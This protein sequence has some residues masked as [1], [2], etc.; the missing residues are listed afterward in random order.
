MRDG[1][2]AAVPPRRSRRAPYGGR[3]APPARPCYP[4]SI[5]QR[6]GVGGPGG[7]GAAR[8]RLA[9]GEGELRRGEGGRREWRRAWHRRGRGPSGPPSGAGTSARPGRRDLPRGSVAR[10]R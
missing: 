5:L 6:R 4:P 7:R 9:A 10:G 8:V 1:G 2:R 3:R